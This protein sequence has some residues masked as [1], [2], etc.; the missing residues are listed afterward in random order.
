MVVEELE[1]LPGTVL[2]AIRKPLSVS[3]FFVTVVVALINCKYMLSGIII[4]Q[5]SRYTR[6]SN[7]HMW[8]SWN[9]SQPPEPGG[10]VG[11]LVGPSIMSSH[12]SLGSPET[13]EQTLYFNKQAAVGVAG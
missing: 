5:M 1:G 10:S 3:S 8:H 6:R 13:D 7:S 4:D 2:A 12:S 9:F 11:R